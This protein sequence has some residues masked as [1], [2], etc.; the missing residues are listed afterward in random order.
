MVKPYQALVRS[1]YKAAVYFLTSKVLF[2]IIYRELSRSF[3]FILV[4]T[5]NTLLFRPA[6][7]K[8]RA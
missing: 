2:K 4:E 6:L 3:M 1:I 5:K 8:M 7:L